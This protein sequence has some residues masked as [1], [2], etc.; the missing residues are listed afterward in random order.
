MNVWINHTSLSHTIHTVQQNSVKSHHV[1]I[2]K[3][4]KSVKNAKKKALKNVEKKIHMIITI[5][6]PSQLA[7]YMIYYLVNKN[8]TQA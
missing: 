3:K 8:S 7:L 2:K 4:K 1:E 6:K 5:N